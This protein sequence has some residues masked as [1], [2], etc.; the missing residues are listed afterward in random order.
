MSLMK[1]ALRKRKKGGGNSRPHVRESF[2]E[3]SQETLDDCLDSYIRKV[4]IRQALNLHEYHSLSVQQAESSRSL[5]KTSQLLKCLGTVEPS[6]KIKYRFLRQSLTAMSNKF[7][8]ELLCHWSG[9]QHVLAG[10]AADQIGILLNHWRRVTK[11]EK[12]WAKFCSRLDDQAVAMVIDVRPVRAAPPMKVLKKTDTEITTDSKGF[13]AMVAASVSGQEDT[14]FS[15]DGGESSALEEFG[16][17]LLESPPPVLKKD[18]RNQAGKPLKRPAAQTEKKPATKA[19]STK[20]S[21]GGLDDPL[22]QSSL[23]LGG[24]KSQSYIQH[25]PGGPGTSLKLVVACT[26]NQASALTK[27]HR[28]VMELLLPA[29]KQEGATKRSVLAERGKLF[30]KYKK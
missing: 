19:S 26:T 25:R 28:R 5:V 8:K 3:V 15:T 16:D 30:A 10:K 21:D 7:G 23:V 11:D 6:F 1:P 27:G 13:P 12:A 22:E 14:D 24:G 4:G 29:C 20:K 2:P 17:S 9:E 18:W